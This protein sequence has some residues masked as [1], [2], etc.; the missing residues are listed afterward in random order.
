MTDSRHSARTVSALA[1]VGF[2]A[3][4][5]LVGTAAIVSH[6]YDSTIRDSFLASSE[7]QKALGQLQTPEHEINDAVSDA[8]AYLLHGDS[9]ELQ[10]YTDAA[11]KVANLLR[12][13]NEHRASEGWP[14]AEA[15]TAA[16]HERLLS[17][18]GIVT[19]ARQGNQKAAVTEAGTAASKQLERALEAGI[20]AERARLNDF[21]L[22]QQGDA[23]GFHHIER[24]LECCK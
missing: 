6:R 15:L 24:Q 23:F 2:V 10:R 12:E 4:F 17:L 9:D 18:N 7:A 1:L 22:A 20:D 14:K 13:M 8:R 3:A 5:V 21:H 11:H 16:A 19:L